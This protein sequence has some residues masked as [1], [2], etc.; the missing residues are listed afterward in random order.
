MTKKLFLYSLA[1][2]WLPLFAEFFGLVSVDFAFVAF[3]TG[4]MMLVITAFIVPFFHLGKSK[5]SRN[6]NNGEHAHE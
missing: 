4:L 5:V 2:M 6:E 3:H 1:V